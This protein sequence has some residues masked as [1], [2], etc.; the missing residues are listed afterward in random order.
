MFA[1]R[2]SERIQTKAPRPEP[3]ALPPAAA[4]VL[5]VLPDTWVVLRDGDVQ[6]A[7]S[8]A[9][10]LGV[11]RDGRLVN[12]QL[13]VLSAA[14]RRDGRIRDVEVEAPR[15]GTR[16]PTNLAVRVAPLPGDLVLLIVDDRSAKRRVDD[17]RRDFVANVSHELKTPIGALILLAEAS[18]DAASDPESVRRFAGRMQHEATRLSVMV[19][20]LIDLSRLQSDDPL[21]HA[22]EVCVD[23]L[24][25][26]AVD[27]T[28]T[29]A[30]A[31]QISL[32]VGG[33]SGL[34][35]YGDREQLVTALGNLL[36]NA[37][38]YSNPRTKIGVA[39][40]QEGAWVE[41]SI[42]DQG[43]GIPRADLDRIFERF[44]RVDPA[45]SRATGGTGLGLSIVKHVSANHGGEVRVWSLEGAGS[46]FTLR[47]PLRVS[48]YVDPQVIPLIASR[49]A[50][51][52]PSR[53]VAI[54]PTRPVADSVGRSPVSGTDD[55]TP[56]RKAL[57]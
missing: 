12:E 13:R 49:P 38:K 56:E 42:T 4:A 32:A 35:I 46:T 5:S 8:A 7:G 22:D 54:P 27:R 44:Y 3:P 20:E 16:R 2:V 30:T 21:S 33:D 10:A 24:I 6:R 25:D 9:A 17:V 18:A 37:V 36:D 51:A 47:L 11:V 39:T 43:I 23:E 48:G 31:K 41:I 15:R 14:V 29:A 1:F 55:R 45:R 50:P 26:D 57:P 52:T 19:N 53:P 34:R 40:R 28:R